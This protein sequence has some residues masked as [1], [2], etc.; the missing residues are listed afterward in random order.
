MSSS[1]TIIFAAIYRAQGYIMKLGS[2]YLFDI[3][4]D[5]LNNKQ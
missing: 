4:F 5:P 2:I 3:D 1:S